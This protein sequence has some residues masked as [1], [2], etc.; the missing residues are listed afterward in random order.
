MTVGKP[1]VI[2][3]LIHGGLVRDRI[4][5]LFERLRI[6]FV[7]FIQGFAAFLRRGGL[8]GIGI[9]FPC[10]LDRMHAGVVGIPRH[11]FGRRPRAARGARAAAH[12]AATVRKADSG[13]CDRE[14]CRENKGTEMDSHSNLRQCVKRYLPAGECRGKSNWFH[15][16]FKKSGPHRGSGYL[17]RRALTTLVSLEICTSTRDSWG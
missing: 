17:L 4:D 9:V 14:R 16:N 8:G 13:G 10:F 6:I 15:R 1:D 5:E 2:P 7:G 3:R 11:L 12:G